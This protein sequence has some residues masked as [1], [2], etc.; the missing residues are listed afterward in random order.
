MPQQEVSAHPQPRSLQ[1]TFPPG[2]QKN[3]TPNCFPF[4]LMQLHFAPTGP[5]RG[6]LRAFPARGIPRSQS[7]TPRPS[8]HCPA[9]EGAKPRPLCGGRGQGRGARSWFIV[10][11]SRPCAH[12]GAPA[13]SPDSESSLASSLKSVRAL[14]SPRRQLSPTPPSWSQSVSQSDIVIVTVTVSDLS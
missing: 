9:E 12:L 2:N 14:W 5:F 11:S 3:V 7:E 1:A 13:L 10:C 8:P 4:S 6:M